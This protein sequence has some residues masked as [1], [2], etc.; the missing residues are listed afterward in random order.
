MLDFPLSSLMT[1]G[2]EQEEE[3]RGVIKNH[4]LHRLERKSIEQNTEHEG[5]KKQPVAK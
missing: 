2:E 5:V 4:P 3:V 1:R